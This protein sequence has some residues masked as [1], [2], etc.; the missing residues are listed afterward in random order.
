MLG[1]GLTANWLEISGELAPAPSIGPLGPP[2]PTRYDAFGQHPRTKAEAP[3]G[4]DGYNPAIAPVI[5][6]ALDPF[7][8]S[9]HLRWTCQSG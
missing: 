8:L 3:Q 4:A 2:M 5:S 7:A 9:P 1:F 6:G